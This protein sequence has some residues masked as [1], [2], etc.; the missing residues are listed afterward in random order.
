MLMKTAEPRQTEAQSAMAALASSGTDLRLGAGRGPPCDYES[1]SDP[2][3][4]DVQKRVLA[5][6]VGEE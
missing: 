3:R 2:R 1:V 4:T 5:E 6:F